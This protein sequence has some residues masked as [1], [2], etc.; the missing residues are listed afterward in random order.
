MASRNGGRAGQGAWSPV[1]EPL[2]SGSKSTHRVGTVQLAKS[3]W[4]Y[5]GQGDDQNWFQ[6]NRARRHRLRE[7]FPG[8]V[9]DALASTPHDRACLIIVRQHL[10]GVEMRAGFYFHYDLLPIP[11]DEIIATILFEVAEG[12]EAEPKS[13]N[14]FKALMRKYG[15]SGT[16]LTPH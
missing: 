6:R 13:A 16:V 11:D 10:Q 9:D 8:E 5:P 2:S 15:S 4:G 12:R 7:P 14:A 3:V 1:D